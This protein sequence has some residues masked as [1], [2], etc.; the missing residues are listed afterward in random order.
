MWEES[1]LLE[2]NCQAAGKFGRIIG[3]KLCSTE[4][5]S[6]YMISPGSESGRQSF[7]EDQMKVWEGLFFL[8]FPLSSQ[9]CNISFINVEYFV[10]CY[11]NKASGSSPK[12]LF[13]SSREK[14]GVDTLFGSIVL[15]AVVMP[16]NVVPKY[17]SEAVKL[18]FPN[19]PI[20]A[21]A[22]ARGSFNNMANERKFNSKRKAELDQLKAALSVSHCSTGKENLGSKILTEATLELVNP[23]EKYAADDEVVFGMSIRKRRSNVY[24]R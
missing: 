13:F 6:K 10:F 14:I 16:T 2:I 4:K 21:Y 23:Y 15:G 19:R 9:D 20:N 3:R 5:I 17:F 22:E 24:K 1:K 12:M 18:K 8:R 7:P 11:E